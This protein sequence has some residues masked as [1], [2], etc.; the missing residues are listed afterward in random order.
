MQST[1][2]ESPYKFLHYYRKKDRDI[3]FGRKAETRVLL[4][5]VAVTRLV[6]LFAK[7]GTGKTS[8][9]NAGVRPILEAEGYAT[10]FIRVKKDPIESA[11]KAIVEPDPEDGPAPE[12]GTAV[13]DGPAAEDGPV[14][15]DGP[16]PRPTLEWPAEKSFAECLE[17]VA[18]DLGKDIVLF[19]DQFEEFFIYPLD[20]GALPAGEAEADRQSDRAEQKRRRDEFISNVA[21]IYHDEKSRVHLVFSMREEWFVELDMF[22]DLIPKIFH[23]ESNL[24]LRWFTK[25]QARDAIRLP[26][27]RFGIEV[28]DEVVE[29]LID[30]LSDNG[31]TEIEPAQLQI[32]CDTLWWSGDGDSITLKDYERLG[33]LD[34]VAGGAA[35]AKKESIARR[36]LF[37]RLRREFEEIKDDEQ[38]RLLY[39]LLPKLGTP[40]GT[41]YVRDI[42][43]LAKELASDDPA[44]REVITDDM[45]YQELVEKLRNGD[46]P[47]RELIA[48]L[49]DDIG[50][51]RTGMRDNLEVVELAHD[52]LVGNLADLQE[53]VRA[54][55]PRRTLQEVMKRD[56][57]A[58]LA[59]PDEV[60]LISNSAGV[61]SFTGEQA[62]KIFRSALAHGLE[63][64]TKLWFTRADENDA[65]EILR[66]C[67]DD[68]DTSSYAIHFLADLGGPRAFDLL[69]TVL[70]KEELAA[71]AIEVVSRKD[72][73]RVIDF[74]LSAARRPK[75]FRTARKAL[76]RVGKTARNAAV[77]DRARKELALLD[78]THPRPRDGDPVTSE[79]AVQS[80]GDG[81]AAAAE[82]H[83]RG[84]QEFE[85]LSTEALAP[86]FKSVI[87]ALGEGRIIMFLGADASRPGGANGGWEPG[88]NLPS[89]R[90]LAA[91]VADR[92]NYPPGRADARDL[93]RVSQYAAT[94]DRDELYRALR[95]V[96]AARPQ[97]SRLHR[98]LPRLSLRSGAAPAGNL[99]L[100][101]AYDD[102]LERAFRE[103]EVP[104]HLLTYLARGEHARKFLHHKP[105]GAAVPIDVPFDYRG[106]TGNLPVIVKVSGGIDREGPVHDSFVITEDDYIEQLS[107]S[108][109]VGLLPLTLAARMRRSPF[110]FLG[111]SP[112]DWNARVLLQRVWGRR[113]PSYQSWAIQASHDPIE[114]A[115]W[116]E[117]GVEPFSVPLDSYAD[118][119]DRHV[120]E[121]IQEV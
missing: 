29:R 71:Y 5:D 84:A 121:Q 37:K 77:A 12:D 13:E 57:G 6:V 17:K 4:S 86:H 14:P 3:F 19:F 35:S 116:R 96:F 63:P 56:G 49:R 38:L 45:A 34:G 108:D 10:F 83:H 88:S 111:F 90:E 66:Q 78:E 7:T 58:A 104:F 89:A 30:D 98:L 114:R 1:E 95:E 42:N 113:R 39:A 112:R 51:V 40:W 100:T 15:E 85:P 117:M 61:L 46:A 103:R 43:G 75:L 87:K 102:L 80:F 68:L 2:P 9:I 59:T 105:D 70:R 8:L 118:E 110:L 76:K 11:R 64:Y 119:L 109:V 81:D 60:E 79:L 101:A 28:T 120:G 50:F 67:L 99:I 91:H 107:L 73:G 55:P 33:Q 31:K 62:G 41:K 48:R 106:L 23:N 21:T 44:L 82:E 24:R 93:A 94:A 32:V 25:S 52:Y 97:P 53:Q 69:E 20:E 18:E 92:F 16:A 26:A 74:L 36:I 115:L 54:I 47:L 72:S 27:Q 65:W 22:R